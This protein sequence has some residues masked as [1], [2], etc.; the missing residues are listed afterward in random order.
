[1]NFIGDSSQEGGAMVTTIILALALLMAALVVGV[2]VMALI[3]LNEI[4]EIAEGSR[5]AQNSTL[6]GPATGTAEY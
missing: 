3:E 5:N 6:L 2:F 1:M 4:E